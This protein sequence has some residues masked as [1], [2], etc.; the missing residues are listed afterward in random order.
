M[1]SCFVG[2]SRVAALQTTLPFNVAVWTCGDAAYK[3]LS[4]DNHA[5]ATRFKM[6]IARPL[7]TLHF[8]RTQHKFDGKDFWLQQEE[9]KQVRAQS[10]N[11]FA[12]RSRQSSKITDRR[13]VESPGSGFLS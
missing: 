13:E 10:T 1:F 5:V 9:R 2:A 6:K 11:L 4:S 8:A 12:L 3:I 7:H